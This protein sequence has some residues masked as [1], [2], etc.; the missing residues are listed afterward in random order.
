MCHDHAHWAPNTFSV[1]QHALSSLALDGAHLKT[2]CND[3]HTQP[4]AGSPR[5]FE[6]TDST[7]DACHL[8]AH[9]GFFDDSLTADRVP[10]H[11]ACEACH[12]TTKFAEIPAPGFDH[13]RFTDFAVRGAHAQSACASCHPLAKAPDES[14]RT[15]GRVEQQFGR[16]EGCVTC[17]KD[18]H[19]GLFDGE[20]LPKEVDGRSDCA[21]CHV[22]SSFR[23]FPNGF[24]HGRWT[25]FQLV[26]AHSL[27]CSACHEP[28]RVPDAV[29]RTWQAA[30]GQECSDCHVNPHAGQFDTRGEHRCA[31][32][33]TDATETFLSF[34]HDRD[35]RFP[36]REQH[37]DLA[38]SA[39][40][41]SSTSPEGDEV[42]RYRPLGIECVDCHGVHED[43][44]M[45][46]RRRR[47]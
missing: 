34:N 11:G 6:G 42:V 37:A 16:F 30:L 17:H 35:S 23:S 28:L 18:P 13:E 7:C 10:K 2:K 24:D 20:K 8:D 40:H 41:K 45:H 47:N 21:R 5:Q 3:C 43:V 9:G 15:F 33:H 4:D 26:G 1:E 14:G 29:G 27:E 44:L 31:Q 22:E 46:R 25:G 38:C 12:T 19:Q 39:C 32:C 36:L